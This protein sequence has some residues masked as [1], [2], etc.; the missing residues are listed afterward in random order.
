M[1]PLKQPYCDCAEINEANGASTSSKRTGERTDPDTPYELFVTELNKR[2]HCKH[3]NYTVQW[4]SIDDLRA[5][6]AELSKSEANEKNL[7]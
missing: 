4:L 6:E 3:C 2:G 1:R 5:L 7:A